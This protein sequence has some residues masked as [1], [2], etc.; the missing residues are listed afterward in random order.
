VTPFYIAGQPDP[1]DEA[2]DVGPMIS[3]DAAKRVET[4]VGEALSAG[5]TL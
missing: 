4:W 5:A 1:N 2:A 3:E